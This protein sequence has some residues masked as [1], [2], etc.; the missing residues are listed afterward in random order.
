FIRSRSK[1]FCVMSFIEH[2]IGLDFPNTDQKIRFVGTTPLFV[3]QTFPKPT[4]DPK[5]PSTDRCFAGFT[6]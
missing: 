5:A 2:G 6:A 1:C 3:N 4:P